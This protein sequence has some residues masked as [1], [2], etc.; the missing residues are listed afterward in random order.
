MSDEDGTRPRSSTDGRHNEEGCLA[1]D[2]AVRAKVGR[3]P[4]G[5]VSFRSEA[6]V[7]L[8]MVKTRSHFSLARTYG[9]HDSDRLRHHGL[10]GDSSYS[11]SAR[12]CSPSCITLASYCSMITP[13]RFYDSHDPHTFLSFSHTTRSESRLT[14]ILLLISLTPLFL[15]TQPPHSLC[16]PSIFIYGVLSSEL[17][18][19]GH[20]S[21]YSIVTAQCSSL[22]LIS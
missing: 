6:Y 3:E 14:F 5:Y 21:I 19:H 9:H 18:C 22:A 15:L 7:P 17:F 1:V 4:M 13:L 10:H 8:G 20:S 16:N 12:H 11:T 2:K